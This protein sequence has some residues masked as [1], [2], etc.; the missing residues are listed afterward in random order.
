MW[1]RRRLAVLDTGK[2]LSTHNDGG[3]IG[4][5]FLHLV[6]SNAGKVAVGPATAAAAE[7]PEVFGNR[8]GEAI[9]AATE[10]AV[11]PTA[12]GLGPSVVFAPVDEALASQGRGRHHSRKG[13]S[14]NVRDEHVGGSGSVGRT[15]KMSASLGSGPPKTAQPMTREHISGYVCGD[16]SGSGNFQLAEE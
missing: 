3:D 11:V 13:D 8:T 4:A 5:A 10:N 2:S 6:L 12:A 1:M 9:V 16:L 14:S 15:V 7:S